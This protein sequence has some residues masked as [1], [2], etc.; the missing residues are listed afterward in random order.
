MHEIVGCCVGALIM[1]TTVMII[2][3]VILAIGWIAYAIWEMKMRAEEKKH[4]GRVSSE[5]L[6]KTRSEVADWARKMAEFE[7]PTRKKEHK[8]TREQEHK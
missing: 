7:P 4:P 3:V 8:N 1:F 5:R 2:A 6:K